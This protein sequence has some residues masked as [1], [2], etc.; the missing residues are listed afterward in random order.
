MS[1]D[2][3]AKPL[4]GVKVIDLTIAMAGP[5]AT[6]R[7]GDLGAD[8]IKVEPPGDGDLTRIFFLNNLA[9][10]SES[11]S[12]LALNRNKRSMVVNL[13]NPEG[14]AIIH[15]LVRKADVFIQ[16]FRPGVA[17]KLGVD[18]ETL[19]QINPSIIYGAV[20]GYGDFSPMVKAPGQDL[21]AQAFS[22]LMFSG[23]SA[24]QGP[25]PSP[26]YMADTCASHLLTTGIVSAL[27]QR[28]R[29][30]RGS[31][32]ETSL[33][34]GLYEMQSQEV[35]TFMAT[36]KAAQQV[37][38]PLASVWLDPPYGVY[39]TVDG[40]LA[41]A[42]NDLSVIAATL[43]LPALEELAR[44]KPA[45]ATSNAGMRWK[46]DCYRALAA[47]VRERETRELHEEFS[48][49]GVWCMPVHS[50][51]DAMRHEQTQHFISSFHLSGVGDVK[52]AAPAVSVG[53]NSGLEQHL[54]APPGLGEHT[55]EI[56]QEFGF[57]SESVETYI[58]NGA[59]A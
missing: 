59:L 58:R 42:Q 50:F 46:S 49:R 47:C 38:A 24:A 57:S 44:N 41:F 28:E 2:A 13:K 32:V 18:F 19:K 39:Q 40:W 36:G 35:M 53:P 8:I 30:G 25:H 12:Y 10:G 5:L 45:D 22:G 51:E 34:G 27:F 26:C 23:G 17:K 16:N 9:L 43:D 29:T 54:S 56:M 48:E 11:T 31:M 52:C 15:E 20:T 3:V 7:L 55:R 6:Q 37:D 14:V 4:T 21:L 33:I 1:T